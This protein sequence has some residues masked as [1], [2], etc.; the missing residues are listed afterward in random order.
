MRWPEKLRVMQLKKRKGVW[1]ARNPSELG[2]LDPDD[3]LGEHQEERVYVLEKTKKGKG[4]AR[5]AER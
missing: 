2:I 4:R 1:P 3:A 5:N